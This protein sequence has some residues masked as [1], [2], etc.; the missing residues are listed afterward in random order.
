MQQHAVHRTS[1]KSLLSVPPS[2]PPRPPPPTLL[3]FTTPP[4]YTVG[5]RYLTRNPLPQTQIEYLT[6]GGG[7]GGAHL[8]S[9]HPAP[10]GGDLTYHGPGQVTGY[11]IVDLRAHRLT[12][13]NYIHLLER[14]VIETAARLGVARHHVD[15]DPCN[16]G[17]WVGEQQRDRKLCALGVRV[18]AGGVTSHGLGLNVWDH[19]L[20]PDGPYVD[21]PATPP[22]PPLPGGVAGGKQAISLPPHPPPRRP[23]GY[24]SWGFGRIVAC[25]LEG[26]SVTWLTA[27]GAD[28]GLR[29]EEVGKLL[30]EEL[31]GQLNSPPPGQSETMTTTTRRT[32]QRGPTTEFVEVEGVAS[33]TGD[34]VKILINLGNQV[35]DRWR[36]E[37]K[38]EIGE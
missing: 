37:G 29:E 10:R 6:G 34:Q 27:E 5:R 35:L 36:R 15:T 19:L 38:G 28:P 17:V 32:R 18:G 4:T 3:T 12:A 26:K 7:G 14:V 30:A 25:G 8:A 33:V 16:P 9:Y 20:P 24:L 13:R 23:Q 22:P 31:A 21:L 1:L 2:I 11:V